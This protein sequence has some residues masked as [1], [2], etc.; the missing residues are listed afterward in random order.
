MLTDYA[1]A[2]VAGVLAFRLFREREDQAVRAFW[3]LGFAALSAAAALGGS[4]HGFGGALS[5]SFERVLW[6]A[7]G[8]A[9]GVAGF[10]MYAGSSF[11]V[12]S[13]HLRRLLLAPAAAAVVLYLIWMRTHSAYIYVIIYTGFLM[14]LIAAMHGWSAMRRRDYPS[15]WMVAGVGVSLSAAGVQAG[16]VVLR[17]DFDHNDLYHVMQIVA[18]ILFF[19]GARRLRDHTPRYP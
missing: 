16:G 17:P 1:L 8:L 18:I 5:A 12:S 7:T 6:K 14:I 13:G 19:T 9:I 11:A 3:A 4:D 15:I 2:L 10:A